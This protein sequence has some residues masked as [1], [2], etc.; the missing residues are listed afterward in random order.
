M[1]L[2]LYH[3]VGPNPKV[4]SMF[5]QEKGM[6]D[7]VDV[8]KVDLAAMENRQEAHLARNPMGQTPSLKLADGRYLSESLA[9]CE[10]LEELQPEPSLFGRTPEE[11]A[12]TRMW[13]RRI[14]LNIAHMMGWG[15]RSAEGLKFFTP[16]YEVLIPEGADGLK[17]ATAAALG[18]LDRHFTGPWICG[19]RFS[20]ADILLFSWLEFGN[21]VGQ[22]FDP[23]LRN[24]AGWFEQANSRPSTAA[25]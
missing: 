4:V 25:L 18:W 11:R 7:Q 21:R 12:M 23:G 5:L 15:F 16:R 20:M 24:L 10:Y 9:I 2:T 14:D 17:K 6:L 1:S 22:P 3:S 13:T 19:E 8:V